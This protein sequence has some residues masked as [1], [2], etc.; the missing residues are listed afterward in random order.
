MHLLQ[1]LAALNPC[2]FG[3][4]SAQNIYLR[5]KEEIFQNLVGGLGSI[6]TIVATLVAV[7]GSRDCRN[8][9]KNIR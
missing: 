9:K 6:A 3:L 1:F 5:N 2:L 7:L 8:A 4:L